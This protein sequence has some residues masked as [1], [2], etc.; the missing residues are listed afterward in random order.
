MAVLGSAGFSKMPKDCV[1]FMAGFFAFA[2]ILNWLHYSLPPNIGR[3]VLLP[4]AM[5]SVK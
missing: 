2:I 1:E 3:F 5:V 4:M